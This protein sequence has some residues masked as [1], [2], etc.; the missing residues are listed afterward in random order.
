M[1]LNMLL[2]KSGWYVVF[3][4]LFRSNLSLKF[5]SLTPDTRLQRLLISNP[6]T[7]SSV[8]MMRLLTGSFYTNTTYWP[9]RGHQHNQ[10]KTWNQYIDILYWYILQ[11]C[12]HAH[13][14]TGNPPD[15]VWI[16]EFES[17]LCLLQLAGNKGPSSEG[18]YRANQ[19]W[20][21]KTS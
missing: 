13:M 7:S 18:R 10:W 11:R 19:T 20:C 5:D 2:F 15:N 8:M 3:L 14:L 4:I 21:L 12:H 1:L 6:A 17:M 9:S 16:S